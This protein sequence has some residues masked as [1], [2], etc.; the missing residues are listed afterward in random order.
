MW[1]LL[2]WRPPAVIT[3]YVVGVVALT[4]LTSHPV[5][6]PRYVMSAFPL[7]IPAA[8]RL[9]GRAYRLILVGSMVLMALLFAVTS[10]STRLPP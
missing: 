7:L 5:S 8:D 6:L 4:V 10:V 2:R 3:V 1:L 9:R